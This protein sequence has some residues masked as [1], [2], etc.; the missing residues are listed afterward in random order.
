MYVKTEE[1][2]KYVNTQGE[3]VSN[4]PNSR[5]KNFKELFNNLLKSSDVTTA[6]PVNSIIISYD[7]TKAVCVL[8]KN[9]REYYVEMYDLVTYEQTFKEK[10]GGG[11]NQ[12]IKLKEVEQNAK[13]TK[14]AITY[15]DDGLFRM[16]W[17][18][19][20]SR[21]EEEIA[22]EELDISK[23]LG[24]D[25][26][27]MAI[28]GFPDPYIVCSFLDDDRIFVNLFYNPTLT[29]Y[30]FIYD[31][32]KKAIVGKTVTKVL[33][34]SK[35]NFPYK[36]F[37]NDEK[38]EIYTFYRQGQCFIIKGNNSEEF[39]YDRMTDMDL[40]Q[41][42]LVYNKALIARSSSDILFFKL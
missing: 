31:V 20:T 6:Y 26:W 27:T 23:L 16:R 4:K 33:D 5:F 29:H 1:A 7:S 37:Y 24:L 8:K 9:D 14:F 36:S 10:V 17:F 15:F 35:K 21:T 38:D 40:G 18:G 39:R 19:K 11:E 12:Y 32:S 41:M 2:L 30:H 28:N 3:T 13:G 42:Y 34:C 22:K 25:N